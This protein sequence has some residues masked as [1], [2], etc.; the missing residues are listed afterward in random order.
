MIS[1]NNLRSI[2]KLYKSDKLEHGYIEI[3]DQYFKDIRNKELK[4]LL[5]LA[6]IFIKLI[7]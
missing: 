3:Y 7:L 1:E 2:A 6:L 4:I 5:L